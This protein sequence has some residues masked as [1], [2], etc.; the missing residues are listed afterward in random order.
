MATIYVLIKVRAGK[1]EDVLKAVRNIKG[2][3]EANA[4][5]GR[6][7]IV[8]KAVGKSIPALLKTVIQDIQIVE[9]VESTESLITAEL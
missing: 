8:A 9:G 7:D 2:I 4:V 5:T 3:E 6:C 1:V